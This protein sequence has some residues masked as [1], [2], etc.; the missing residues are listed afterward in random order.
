[1]TRRDLLILLAPIALPAGAALAGEFTITVDGTSKGRLFEGVG[2]LS[3]GASSRLLYDYPEPQRSEILDYLFKPAFGASLHHLKVE[4]GGDVNSTDGSEPSHARTREE[5]ENPKP[6]YFERGYEWW[7]MREARNRNPRILIEALQ[8]GAPGWIGNGRFYSEDNAR[9]VAAFIKGARQYHGVDIDYVGVWNEKQYD[10]EYI[11]LL[12]RVLDSSGFQRVK[13][14]AADLWEPQ[15]K[16]TIADAMI[17]DP[18]LRKSIAALSAHITSHTSFFTTGNARKLGI[19]IWDGE[20]H[21][22]GGDWYGAAHHAR[23]N[24]A[25][26]VG[27]I[28]SLVSWSL[29]TSYQDFLPAPKSGPMRAASPWSG[30]YEVQPPIWILAHFT[31]FAQPG[32]RYLDSA[33]KYFA[34]ES[35]EVPKEGFSVTALRSPDTDDYTILI[36][37]M[38]AKEPQTA[39]FRVTGGLSTRELA[40]WRSR[41]EQDLF[42]RLDDIRLANDRFSIRLEPNSMYSLTT[43]RGQRK[44][45]FETVIPAERPFPFPY[46]DDFEQVQAGRTPRYFSDQHGTFEVAARPDGRGKCLMQTVTQQGICWRPYDYPQTILGDIDWRDYGVSVDFFLPGKGTVKLVGRAQGFGW[47]DRPYT[48]YGIEIE[49]TGN[50]QLRAGEKVLASGHSAAVSGQWHKVTL[51]LKGDRLAVWLDS[52]HVAQVND[53]SIKSGL[54]A[55]GTGWNIGMFDNLRIAAAE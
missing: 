49:D 31:Q 34:N 22:Y 9:F 55:L 29:I 28:T 11:K 13:I 51:V 6:E 18:D 30:H 8:W 41:F 54:V 40:A 43:T 44:G 4:I 42:L 16:W 10:V 35:E 12:R 14:V 3:A 33:C 47:G 15:E 52:E 32:W 1:M 17:R 21:A 50:W 23:Q 53:D 19:P 36:E 37:T 7:L 20:V 26:P 24:R 39:T 46:S 27:Q 2:A 38:D 45:G 48:G 5:F 25:Y